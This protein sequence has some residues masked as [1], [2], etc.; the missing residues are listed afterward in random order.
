MENFE[1]IALQLTDKT[2]IIFIIMS[3]HVFYFRRHAVK[4]VLE[5]GFTP[6]SQYGIFDYFMLDSVDRDLVRRGNNNLIRISD[7]LWVFG[8]ISDGVLAEI[9]LAKEINKPVKYFK[10]INSKEI[11]EISKKDVN[12]EEDL[13]KY[14]YEL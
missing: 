14:S 10:I 9:K 1:H 13:E 4:Y 5:S 12:F 2:K 11:K 6:I 8:P 3:K 7:E